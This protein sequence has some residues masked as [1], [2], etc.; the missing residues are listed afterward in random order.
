M[1]IGCPKDFDINMNENFSIES[2]NICVDIPKEII[3][4]HCLDNNGDNQDVTM[5]QSSQNDTATDHNSN[6][7]PMHEPPIIQQAPPSILSNYGMT[8]Q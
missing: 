8:N 4:R 7:V 2:Q 3:R 1:K 6:Q 5:S